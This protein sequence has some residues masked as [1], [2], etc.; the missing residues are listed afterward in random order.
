MDLHNPTP[1]GCHGKIFALVCKVGF[2]S[3]A[4]FSVRDHIRG[5]HVQR[6]QLRGVGYVREEH[7]VEERVLQ[8]CGDVVGTPE[9]GKTRCRRGRRRKATCLCR[10]GRGRSSIGRNG[11]ECWRPGRH[12]RWRR[13]KLGVMTGV[14]GRLSGGGGGRSTREIDGN[15]DQ[16]IGARRVKGTAGPPW[17]GS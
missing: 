15:R 9:G 11:E 5:S 6:P 14:D 8:S 13:A 7:L 16:C 1:L 17:A 3:C 2:F 4:F 12:E 10:K